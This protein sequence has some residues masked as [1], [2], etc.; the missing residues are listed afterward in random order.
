MD[1]PVNTPD[2][3]EFAYWHRV[4]SENLLQAA[5]FEDRQIEHLD[6]AGD[7]GQRALLRATN[8]KERMLAMGLLMTV[9]AIVVLV[10]TGLE[11]GPSMPS[12]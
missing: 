1:R 6:A 5:T 2:D 4:A 7:Y 10:D 9:Q 11:T 8:S 3:R 12:P